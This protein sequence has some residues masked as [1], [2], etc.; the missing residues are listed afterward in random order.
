MISAENRDAI[1]LYGG[2]IRIRDEEGIVCNRESLDNVYGDENLYKTINVL[3]FPGITNE[4]DRVFKEESSLNEAFV[5]RIEETIKIYLNIFQAMC[6]NR[7]EDCEGI[8]T[9]YRVEREGAINALK[10]GKTKSFLSA[11]L[12]NYDD[13]FAE[14]SSIVLVKLH[15]LR[16]VPYIDFHKVLQNEYQNVEEQ[17]VLIAPFIDVE[18]R[19]MALTMDEKN[20]MQDMNGNPP[21]RK[22]YM[23][24]AQFTPS[25]TSHDKS[26]LLKWIVS[27]RKVAVDAIN[28]MNRGEWDRDFEQYLKWKGCLQMYL[29]QELSD[30]WNKVLAE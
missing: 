2:D 15:M 5:E 21:V 28:A 27:N 11:S 14:K 17:E 10:E 6:E 4:Y 18:L 9:A 25:A 8:V 22:Y 3:L 29:Y 19:E 24:V 26:E 16:Q 13:T 30:L 7:K 20:S 1:R 23:Y 12:T